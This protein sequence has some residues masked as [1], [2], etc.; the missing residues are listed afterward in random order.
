M[1]TD[2]G[3]IMLIYDKPQLSGQPPL[4]GLLPSLAT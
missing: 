3:K 2:C 4:T 1:M